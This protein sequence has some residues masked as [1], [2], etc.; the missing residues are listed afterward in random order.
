MFK[1]TAT[2]E[3]ADIV[4][5]Q[6]WEKMHGQNSF[7]SKTA[8][9]TKVAADQSKYLLSHCTIMASVAV[10]PEPF[11]YLIKPEASAFVN[12]NND[13]W[14][15]DVLRMSYRTFVGAFNFL[16]HFQNSKASKGHV[17]DAVLRKIH[18]TPDVEVAYVDILVATDLVHESLISDIKSGK[19][20]YMS[21]GCLT[22]MV[23]CTFCGAKCT[24][25]HTYCTHLLYNKG[26]FLFDEGGVPR[27]IAELCGHKTLPGVGVKFIEASFVATPAFPGAA[28]RS[29]ITE[30]WIG[31]KTP[32]SSS[33][34][35]TTGIRKASGVSVK[36]VDWRLITHFNSRF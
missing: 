14:S 1:K 2:A 26:D 23:Q 28:K 30:A 6:A 21:M 12:Q 5:M 15:T 24:E 18:L 7:R 29:I 8:S 27:R 20:K 36:K 9:V 10:E 35:A 25:A 22:D 31:P 34:L 19:T 3:L 17:L 33:H 13:C 32:Y 16:E 11:D 4:S